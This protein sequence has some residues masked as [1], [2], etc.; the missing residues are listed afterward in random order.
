MLHMRY[1]EVWQGEIEY[2]V[3]CEIVTRLYADMNILAWM[4]DGRRALW[5]DGQMVT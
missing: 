3:E 1:P 2:E 4:T 5:S